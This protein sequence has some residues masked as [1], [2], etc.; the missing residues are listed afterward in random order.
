MGTGLAPRPLSSAPSLGDQ[1]LSLAGGRKGQLVASV[2]GLKIGEGVSFPGL[3]TKIGAFLQ[4]CS[5][6]P[7]PSPFP[8]LGPV[9]IGWPLNWARCLQTTYLPFG[10]PGPFFF[11]QHISRAAPSLCTCRRRCPFIV[12]WIFPSPD[13]GSP[14]GGFSI[15]RHRDSGSVCASHRVR[16]TIPRGLLWTR[17]AT[18]ALLP[19][20]ALLGSQRPS[21]LVALLF[22]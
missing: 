20:S 7:C 10:F 13:D 1:S 22:L 14:R 11:W 3:S 17:P 8:L 2:A 18:A 4:S 19:S 9:G 21:R 16:W 5:G 6:F 15:S 12:Q